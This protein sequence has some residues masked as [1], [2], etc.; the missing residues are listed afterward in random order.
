MKKLN[1]VLMGDKEK[2]E[3]EDGVPEV[4]AGGGK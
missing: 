4:P 3:D 2:E 1:W